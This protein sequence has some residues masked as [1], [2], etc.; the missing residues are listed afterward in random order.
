LKEHFQKLEAITRNQ[1]EALLQG[2][3]TQ[4]IAR[5]QDA[6]KQPSLLDSWVEYLKIEKEARTQDLGQILD[7]FAAKPKSTFRLDLAYEMAVDASVLKRKMSGSLFQ[8]LSFP[9][10]ASH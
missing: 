6:L 2:S 8:D 7:F 4:L 3:I 5:I 9:V 1:F 10:V